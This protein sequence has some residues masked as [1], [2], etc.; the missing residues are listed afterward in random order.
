M[1]GS[2]V[3]LH[4]HS[5]YSMMQGVHSPGRLCREARARGY[6]AIAITDTNGFHGLM[7]FLEAAKEVGIRPI[8][9]AEVGDGQHSAIFIA[10]T[11]RGYELLCE[12]IS[13]RHLEKRFSL[14]LEVPHVPDDLALLSADPD[15]LKA[16]R[17][18]VQC[19]V[20]VIPGPSDRRAMGISGSLGIPPLATNG[21]YFAD[22]ESHTLHRLL[23][24]IARNRTLSTLPE[25]EV[26]S[27]NRWL[28]PEEE[29]ARRL[30]HAPEAMANTARLAL[31]CHTDWDH[32]KPVFPRYLDREEDHFGQLEALCREGV[33]WRYGASNPLV[34]DRLHEELALIRKMGFVDYFLVVRDIVRRRPVHC[35]RG[36]GAAS[37][38]SYL[39][40][41]THVDPIR[42]K[43]VFSRF[44][45]PERRDFPD[46]DVDF[47]WDERDEL[48]QEVRSAYGEER[49]AMIANHVGFGGRAAV[50]E[51][52]KVFGIPAV[53]IREV[54]RRI[55]YFWD[56]EDLEKG[57]SDHPR[58][59]GVALDPPWPE[60]LEL[61]RRLQSIPRMLSTH[62]G[63]MVL[64]P[65]RVSRYVPVQRS[66]KKVRI[67]QWEKDQAESAGLVKMDL[68]G[69]RSLAVIRDCIAAVHKNTG[70]L[71]DYA[72][73]NPLDDEK[74][75][76]LLAGG[77]T[78]GVFYVESPAMRL[79]QKKTG[80]GD[81]EHLTIHSSIIRPA[82]NKY[83]RDYIRRLH[84]E[85]YEPI[86]PA[87]SGLL[88]ET[89]GILSYQEDVIQVSM[90][91]AGFTWGEADGLRKIISRKS[92]EKLARYR[93]RFFEGCS[94]RTVS[95]EVAKKVW[96]MI[97]SFSGY[98]F[99]KPHSASYAMVSF[100][101]A[102]L[103]AHHPAEFMAA[104]ISNGGGYYSPFAYISEARRMG[105]T[106]LGPDVNE[107]EWAYT[108]KERTLRIGFQQLQN[109]RRETLERILDERVRNGP[110]TSLSDWLRRVD[111]PPAD[112]EVLVQSGVL[113][114]ISAPFNRPQTMWVVQSWLNR[115][116][117]NA[118]RGQKAVFAGKAIS[119][120]SLRDL[121]LEQKCRKEEETLGFMI[122]RHPLRAAAVE[123]KLP[124]KT[125]VPARDL[126][127]HV[128]RTVSVLGWPITRKE[129]HTKDDQPMEFVSFE[130]WTALYEV[131]L[132]P[133]AYRRYCNEV[134]MGKGYLLHG[135]VE[136][137]F[138]AVSLTLRRV[139]GINGRH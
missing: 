18:K 137:E 90:A 65:D 96:E 112:G 61:A 42:H 95:G 62:C 125:I 103:K 110:F 102:Y 8:V 111:I 41:I 26:V 54:T 58:F 70:K 114:S 34:E 87:L 23:R 75:L 44:L 9:G 92:P 94:A 32:F 98:S 50:R 43:L 47:P 38:V 117:L 72:L 129:V 20:E 10:K 99:C 67:I 25:D 22:P 24:A 35:G 68:L 93:E 118:G 2:F 130:D 81:F 119:P 124:W 7:N 131:V 136:S 63:G 33:L 109:I 76:H 11:V 113:D 134:N 17:A 128:G 97:L 107:S 39:L 31:E 21:V 1:N 30:P 37:L 15:L 5:Y 116:S 83:I 28:M 16:A 59:R 74:T 45:N 85:P 135:A 84:G 82:A 12:L 79:L 6:E 77:D 89:Y 80:K 108:G 13:R 127:K 48:L 57:I 91:L 52:A 121:T 3:H 133:E 100:K 126:E 86:H 29:M 139:N 132:F 101:S 19:W 78:M 60:I 49:T 120:P 88:S 36:S 138:G 115:G 106:V 51:V 104:V 73:F 69:N 66:A 122:S 105:I 53:E 56:P 27:S 71:I 40:G 4:V 64:V 46:I 55:G 14:I 123:A